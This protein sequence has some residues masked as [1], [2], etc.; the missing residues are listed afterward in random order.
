MQKPSRAMLAAI[1]IVVMI[2]IALHL[3]AWLEPAC[4]N[5]QRRIIM[6]MSGGVGCFEFWL[7]RYQ[8]LLGS[9]LTAAVAAV[10]LFWIVRQLHAANRQASVAAA[11][12]MRL[13]AAEL[14]KEIE[15]L[16]TI[17]PLTQPILVA[18]VDATKPD[19]ERR[20]WAELRMYWLGAASSLNQATNTIDLLEKGDP[21]GPMAPWR[22]WLGG[23]LRATIGNLQSAASLA[24]DPD[25][26]IPEALREI[27][28]AVENRREIL[29]SLAS[30]QQAVMDEAEQVW[31]QVRRFE[32]DAIA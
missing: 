8:S 17:M 26:D 14:N 11:G 25:A 27:N 22:I 9:I 6:K 20:S 23:T 15:F 18:A 13:R 5:E 31:A 30:Y 21:V 19:D 1:A 28:R 29:R 12:A 2:A 24:I 10:T 3:W 16:L 32:R 7:N 4:S